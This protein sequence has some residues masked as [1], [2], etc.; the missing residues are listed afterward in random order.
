MPSNIQHYHWLGEGKLY[1]SG[2]D[3]PLA[4]IQDWP[5]NWAKKRLWPI[6]ATF[7]KMMQYGQIW[8]RWTRL[9]VRNNNM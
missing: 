5:K 4:I 2:M 3:N 1:R 6:W 8:Y 7:F 9:D